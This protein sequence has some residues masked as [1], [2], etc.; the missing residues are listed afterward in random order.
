MA[1]SQIG[2][3]QFVSMAPPPVYPRAGLEYESRAGV[4]GYAAWKTGNTAE[5]FAVSTFA[6]TA[7][8]AAAIALYGSYQALVGQSPQAIYYAGTALPFLVLV[9]KVEAEEI[10][11][12]VRGVG[13]VLGN[14]AAIVRAKW[15]LISWV[16][17]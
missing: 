13:G 7:S 15:T 2:T 5:R 12:I 8:L 1:N 3:F 9:E 14:S 17:P 10:R 6:D 11:S 4:D 16:Q